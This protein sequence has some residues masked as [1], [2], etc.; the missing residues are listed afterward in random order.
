M[1]VDGKTSIGGGSNK[2]QPKLSYPER[3]ERA[4]PPTETQ[5]THR[6]PVRVSH[7]SL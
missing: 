2:R 6:A 1:V 7:D 4:D 3:L 5:Q